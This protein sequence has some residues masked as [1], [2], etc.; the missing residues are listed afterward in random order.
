M[1]SDMRDYKI[2]GQVGE[3]Y[4]TAEFQVR[5]KRINLTVNCESMVQEYGRK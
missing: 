5:I 1:H 2:T 3:Q 4:E